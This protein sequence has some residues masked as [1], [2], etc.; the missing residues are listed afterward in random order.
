MRDKRSIVLLIE[1]NEKDVFQFRCAVKSVT[2]TV[3]VC[4]AGNVD[5]GCDCLERRGRF[6]PP[7]ALAAAP[8]LIIAN[9]QIVAGVEFLKWV[10]GHPDHNQLPVVLWSDQLPAASIKTL[11][12]AGA[13]DYVVKRLDFPRL[14]SDI[15]SMLQHLHRPSVRGK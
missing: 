14:C 5:D 2:Q 7:K 11:R 3:D 1:G 12:E 15:Y 8:D 9:L 10:R 6:L 13:T 4:V